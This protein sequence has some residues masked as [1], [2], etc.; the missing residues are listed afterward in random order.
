MFEHFGE[1][2]LDNVFMDEAGQ[3][4]PSVR[5]GAIWRAKHFIALGSCTN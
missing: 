4:T 3:A 5:V 1:N 2:T